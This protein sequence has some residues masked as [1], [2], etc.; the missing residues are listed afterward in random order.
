MVKLLIG[1]IAKTSVCL[2][3]LTGLGKTSIAQV[4]TEFSAQGEGRGENPYQLFMFNI[5]TKIAAIYGPFSIVDG[6]P[7][8]A[9]GQSYLTM[10]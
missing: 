3:G 8:V 9:V 1:S 4:F 5:E 6:R 10:K 7:K 2:V